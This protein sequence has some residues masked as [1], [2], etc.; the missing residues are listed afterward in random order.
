V[1][2]A[3]S[4]RQ[5]W[6]SAVAL[7]FKQVE[8]R[9]FGTKFREFAIQSGKGWEKYQKQAARRLALLAGQSPDFFVETKDCPANERGVVVCVVRI[10]AVEVMTDELIAKTPALERAF[11]DWRPGRK[12]WYFEDVSYLKEPLPLKGQQGIWALPESTEAE[13]RKRAGLV[14]A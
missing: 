8:T 9:S 4:L 14:A 3:I 6:A 12:A 5:P 1:I 13:I 11:G 2:H 10:A 7:G